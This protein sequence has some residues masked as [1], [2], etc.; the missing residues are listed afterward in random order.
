MKRINLKTDEG[1]SNSAQ[2]S[3]SISFFVGMIFLILAVLMY[4][5]VIFEKNK[6]SAK[7]Q[8][9]ENAIFQKQ[10]ALN[11][12]E[13]FK[14]IYN[15]EKRLLDLKK[16]MNEYENYSGELKKIASATF[17]E[18]YFQKFD[19]NNFTGYSSYEIEF[20]SPDLSS[21]ARQ[22]TAYSKMEGIE[23]LKFHKGAFSSDGLSARITFD[24]FQNKKSGQ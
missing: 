17:P 24:L 15:F 7:K 13:D 12:N 3:S 4:G 19:A 21:L 16:D 8:E 5:F 20:I 2:K 23:N 9:V 22:I 10:K 18:V 1:N 11:E 6:I 14:K